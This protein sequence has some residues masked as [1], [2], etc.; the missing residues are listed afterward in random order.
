MR[1]LFFLM[2]FFSLPA[3][4]QPTQKDSSLFNFWIGEWDLTWKDPDG[5]TAHG[6]NIIT[7]I[8]NGK[9]IHENFS[10]LSGPRMDLKVKVFLFSIN[11]PGCGNRHGWTIKA[12]TC[13]L[14]AEV[15]E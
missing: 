10:A 4:A 5:T 13:R 15:T 8:L 11:E 2:V 9:V 3:V 12:H 14:P 7:K 6:K 1:F